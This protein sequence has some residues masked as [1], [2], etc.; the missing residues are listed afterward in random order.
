M[1][2]LSCNSPYGQ[3]GMGQ[4]FAYLVETSRQAGELD[5]YYT[6]EP[7][8]NDPSGHEV[9]VHTYG[10]LKYTPLRFFPAW[11][12]YFTNDWFDRAVAGRLPDPTDRFMGFTGKSLHSFQKARTLGFDALELVAPNSHVRNVHRLHKQAREQTGI[13]DTWLNRRQLRKTIREYEKADII[14]THSEYTTQSLIEEGIDPAKLTR[15]HLPVDARFQPPDERPKDDVFRI[16]YVGRVDATKGIP[17]LFEAFDQLEMP[18]AELRIVGGWSTRVMRKYVEAQ[19]ADTERI[20]VSPGDPLPALQRADVF[21]H[22]TFEDGFGYAPME[23]LACGVPV[24]VT[25]DTGMKE[26]VRQGHNGF[27]VPTGNTEA[28]LDRL[29]HIYEQPLAG[30]DSLLPPSA[31]EPSPVTKPVEP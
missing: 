16:V 31:P 21:V 4:H 25:E 6:N 19:L 2:V 9:N 7:K 15:T 3:G 30:E 27:I 20:T 13:S 5:R 22:P 11:K 24:I 17:L 14:Y 29:H 26:Y 12:S 28:I 8:P 23:A 10:L 18:R 1:R